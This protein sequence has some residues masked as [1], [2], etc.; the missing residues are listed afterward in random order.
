M[1]WIFDDDDQIF[2]DDEALRRDFFLR[3]YGSRDPLGDIDN[4]FADRFGSDND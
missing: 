1:D 2:E 3:A 4:D